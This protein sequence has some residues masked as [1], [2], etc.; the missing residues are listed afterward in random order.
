MLEANGQSLP[1]VL[2]LDDGR[3]I[4]RVGAPYESGRVVVIDDRTVTPLPR[5]VLTVGRSPG[6]EFF[7]VARK[8]GV[9]IH[10]GWQGRE[11]A[12]LDWPTGEEGVP[13]GFDA[14]LIDGTPTVTDLIPF[15][16]GERALLVSPDGI[17]VLRPDK[18]VRLLPTK[19]QM[20]DHFKWLRKE[21]PKDP[22]RYGL[23]MEHGAISPDGRWIAA[24]HQSSM[25]YIFEA[26]SFAVAGEIGHSSEYPHHAVFSADGSVVALNSC[27][28]YNGKTLGVPT[29]LLP[30]LKTEPYKP[31]RRVI[32]LEYGSRVYAAVARGDEFI[33]GDANGYLRAFDVKGNFR[34]QH[35]IGSTVGDIDLSRDGRRLV[36]TT[37]A[38][39]LCILDLD[40]GRADPF[41]IGTATHRETRRWLFWK[42]E[43]NPL[44][45]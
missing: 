29:R 22:L 39:F 12:A 32:A 24:G 17:F 2:L 27:H 3:I 4:A 7:A 21:Y 5:T 16:D 25:H 38:G 15:D 11:T 42:A 23:S 40:T 34:W 18:A 41:A 30:G 28:F 45:W 20:R 33:V 36:V 6:R 14:E 31:D 8:S 43:P 44:V 9:T 26:Q 35:F 1:V 37:Y 13:K 19:A 10:R